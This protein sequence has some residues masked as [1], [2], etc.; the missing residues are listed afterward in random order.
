LTCED[1]VFL[2]SSCFL[3]FFYTFI[4]LNKI[5]RM[6][7]LFF[8]LYVL[9]TS[10]I[11]VACGE[12]SEVGKW[13]AADKEKAKK[14]CM[15]EMEKDPEI[16]AMFGKENVEP[17]CDC[18]V[19]KLESKFTPADVEK[20]ENEAATVKI[21]EDCAMA[22]LPQI[23]GTKGAWKPLFANMMK[24]NC[25]AEMGQELDC[26]CVVNK[27]SE[28]MEPMDLATMA[29]EQVG[30]TFMVAAEKCMPAE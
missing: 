8:P 29:P 12:K 13:T 7:K 23:Y 2:N 16:A 4:F 26:D 28:M 20:K 19:A 9:C 21:G 30:M 15:D 22:M 3:I 11:F 27:L 10:F 1:F 24:D 18:G 17:I 6:K 14:S 25:N 5:N